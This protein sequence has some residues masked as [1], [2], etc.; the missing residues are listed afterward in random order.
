[1]TPIEDVE[2]DLVEVK[3]QLRSW[4]RHQV[5]RVYLV[6]ANPFVL[7]FDRLKEIAD[8]IHKYFPECETIGCFS[9][10]NRCYAQNRG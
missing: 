9:R 8:L 3:E 7:K 2:A 4:Q 1:M 5:K 6:G 10:C